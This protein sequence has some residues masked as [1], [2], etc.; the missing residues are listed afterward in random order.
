MKLF[1]AGNFPQMKSIEAE[2]KM[3]DHVRGLGEE[4]RRLL[5]FFYEED[6]INVLNM[7]REEDEENSRKI[8][9]PKSS[10]DS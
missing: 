1:L 9:I 10:S 6:I 3:R 2:K 7:R 5:S 4:Y 8:T